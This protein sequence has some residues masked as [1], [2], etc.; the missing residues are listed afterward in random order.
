M[1]KSTKLTR[2]VLFSFGEAF[3]SFS[4]V[5][6]FVAGRHISAALLAVFAMFLLCVPR[7]S[8]KLF[9]IRLFL[10]LYI[11]IFIYIMCVLAGHSYNLYD[12]VPYWDKYLHALGGVVFG[13]IGFY[14]PRIARVSAKRTRIVCAVFA[15]CFS[16]TLSL[17]WEFFEFG[18][19]LLFHTDMQRDTYVNEIY[20]Y[21]LCEEIGGVGV[22]NDINEVSLDG[23]TLTAGYLDIGLRDTMCDTAAAT[24]GTVVVVL[25]LLIYKGKKQMICL[26]T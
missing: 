23:K 18:S 6:L 4:A 16:M 13:I 14:I 5:Y 20:S 8:E 24:A 9:K 12:L 15:V 2:L 3:C 7:A 1:A 19:D 25:F 10:P 11:L 26:S 22:I 21:E 17:G